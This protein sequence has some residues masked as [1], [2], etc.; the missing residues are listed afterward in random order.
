MALF[1]LAVSIIVG[2]AALGGGDVSPGPEPQEPIRLLSTAHEVD[3]PDE[4]EF[5]LEIE[6]DETITE[7]TLFYRLG[8]R[9]V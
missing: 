6:G 5:T 4:I 8:R 3:F 1:G 2:F 9:D 7:V